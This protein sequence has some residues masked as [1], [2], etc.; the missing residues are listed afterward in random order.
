MNKA[1][2]RYF[3][4]TK[5]DLTLEDFH[6]QFLQT[7]PSHENPL[8]GDDD[9]RDDGLDFGKD[10]PFYLRHALYALMNDA[11]FDV[12]GGTVGAGEYIL[13]QEQS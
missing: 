3:T 6:S 1:D 9:V 10:E 11:F 13:P 2:K 4:P 12:L 7:N 5:N 8:W